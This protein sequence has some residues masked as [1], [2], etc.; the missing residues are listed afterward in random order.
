M[1]VSVNCG[2]LWWVSLNL[3]PYYYGS[4]LGL[5]E[6]GKLPCSRLHGPQNNHMPPNVKSHEVTTALVHCISSKDGV[7]GPPKSPN[8]W[9]LSRNNGCEGHYIVGYFGNPGMTVTVSRMHPQCSCGLLLGTS[10]GGRSP[11]PSKRR[12]SYPVEWEGHI[13]G[14]SVCLAFKHEAYQ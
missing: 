9:P 8:E 6:F 7:P 12:S 3:E 1:A 11:P 10:W 14:R 13:S 4:I 2:S 5:R